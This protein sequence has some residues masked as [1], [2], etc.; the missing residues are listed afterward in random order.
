MQAVGEVRRFGGAAFPA[1]IDKQANGIIGILGDFPAEPG[2]VAAEFHDAGNIAGYK[3]KYPILEG[4]TLLTNS[5]AHMLESMPLEPA[6]FSGLEDDDNEQ[7]L[8]RKIVAILGK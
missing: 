7:T 8:R 4:L 3:A 5:D 6:V 1:H 2:F